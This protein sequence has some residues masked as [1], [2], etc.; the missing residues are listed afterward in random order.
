VQWARFPVNHCAGAAAISVEEYAAVGNG[1]VSTA[2]YVA[3]FS[4]ELMSLTLVC[5]PNFATFLHSANQS[6]GFPHFMLVA[7]N[8]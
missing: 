3:K 2:E 5:L 1:D 6:C 4:E 7:Y 8:S